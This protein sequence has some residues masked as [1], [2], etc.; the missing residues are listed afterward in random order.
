MTLRRYVRPVLRVCCFFAVV[1][2]LLLYVDYRVARAAVMDR[3]LGF[4]ER[5]APYLDDARDVE[6]PRQMRINGVRLHFA[7]GHTEHPPEMVGQWYQGRY[8]GQD[9]NDAVD[10]MTKELTRKGAWPR[11]ANLRETHFG[12]SERGGLVALDYGHPSTTREL[13]DRLIRFVKSG[14]LDELGRMSYVY[15]ER[16]PS[17][18]TRYLTVWSDETFDLNRLIGKNGGDAEGADI[19]GVPRYPGT[20]RLMSADEVGRVER[21]VTY[22]GPGS[23]QTAAMFYRARMA[24]LGW[25]RDER[26]AAVAADPQGSGRTTLIF[27]NG[28]H[29]VIIGLGSTARGVAITAM[30]VR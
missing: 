13:A 28:P 11:G 22:A 23:P 10:G 6:A 8:Q 17:G 14:K 20:T 26:L 2:G 21:L 30:Q 19:D 3:L 1:G 27:S 18:G 15:Y 9:R 25:K 7:A 5:M 24:T 12:D 29:E 16:S 4:G